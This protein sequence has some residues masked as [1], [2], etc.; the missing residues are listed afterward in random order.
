VTW[1]VLSS[2]HCRHFSLHLPLP[3]GKTTHS[4]HV[5]AERNSE[6]AA[7]MSLERPQKRA[8]A[9]KNSNNHNK[10]GKEDER[11][12]FEKMVIIQSVNTARATS[13][14]A[15]VESSLPNTP[16]RTTNE[17]ASLSAAGALIY[18]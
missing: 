2:A 11:P 1:C 7:D 4:S 3:E 18:T 17:N 10:K 5:T 6:P 9:V 16:R 12:R 13:A 15:L 14:R 8:Q